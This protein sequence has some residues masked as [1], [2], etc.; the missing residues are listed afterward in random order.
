[1]PRPPVPPLLRSAAARSRLCSLRTHQHPPFPSLST[2]APGHTVHPSLAYSHRAPN[3]SSSPFSVS[4][5][6]QIQTRHTTSST[7][8]SPQPRTLP[9]LLPCCCVSLPW[10]PQGHCL[11][12]ASPATYVLPVGPWQLDLRPHCHPPSR[13]SLPPLHPMSAQN[14]L[15]TLP[16]RC[17]AQRPLLPPCHPSSCCVNP[18]L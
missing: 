8:T 16:F 4:F 2:R 11:L 12:P 13:T 1:M 6:D 17:T 9:S 14:T 3:F 18:A 7:H 15:H 5:C 10:Q